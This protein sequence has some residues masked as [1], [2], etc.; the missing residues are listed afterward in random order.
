MIL[1]LP[2]PSEVALQVYALKADGS[3]KL[4]VASGTVRVY[5]IVGGS[6][7][8]ILAATP[9]AQVGATNKWRY[10][11]NPGS[12]A[13][14]E[15]VAEYIITDADAL[16]AKIPEDIIVKDIAKQSTL[17]LVQADVDI[18]KKVET[19]RWKIV[20]N[21][22]LFYDDDGTTVL[23]TFDLKDDAGFPSMDRVFERVPAP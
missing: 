6:E 1:Y 15:Y 8:T 12:L 9:L 16:T 18:I 21:Q 20:A 10:V 13:A 4:N 5:Q 19:G 2:N 7:S 23:L 22:M 14:G 3:E 17:L 11:W